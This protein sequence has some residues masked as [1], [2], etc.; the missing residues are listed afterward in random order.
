MPTKNWLIR[1]KSNHILGPVSKEKVIELYHNGSVR[2]EDEICSGN[3]FWFFLREKDQ[4]E[5]YLLGN[6]KQSF[7]PMSEGIDV[8]TALSGKGVERPDDDITMVGGISISEL[9][10]TPAAPQRPR[11]NGSVQVKSAVDRTPAI[12]PNEVIEAPTEEKPEAGLIEAVV[13][14]VVHTVPSP[15]PITPGKG[16]KKAFSPSGNPP[17]KP[18]P[19]RA[20]SDRFV[21]VGT[22]VVLLVLAGML[23]YR[24]RILQ[25]FIQS[26]YS[27]IFPEA[28]AQTTAFKSKKKVFLSR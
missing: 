23:Y 7:N 25:E 16:K 19:K 10:D 21:M 11:P 28:H 14:P 3:G 24:K 26:A 15:T 5:D 6:K 13:R 9:K 17:L 1:T 20:V 18:L 22:V 8:L 27:T 12:V 4:V 2:P